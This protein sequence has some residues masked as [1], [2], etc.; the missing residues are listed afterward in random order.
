MEV[1]G[2]VAPS[3]PNAVDF[4]WLSAFAYPLLSIMKWFHGLIGNWGVAIILLT[5]LV[6]AVTFPLTYKSM[7]S[8]KQMAA[9]QPELQRLRERY[10]DDKEALNRE[11]ITLM[12]TKGYNPVAG[13]LPMIVQMPV[14]FALYKVLYSAIE[15]YHAP[16]FGWILDL[17]SKDPFYVTPILLTGTM[18]FQQKLTPNTATD[19]MQQKMMQWMPVIFGLFMISLPSG[20]SLYML[21]NALAGIVQQIFLNKKL[22]VGN[23]AAKRAGAH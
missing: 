8:M 19:P 10:K 9:I 5:L 1:L 3:L 14:F 6:K 20:L 16:F 17:S 22:D 13:C 21:V 4:G 15:L 12:R 18:Y 2:A 11:M 7:K 23:V